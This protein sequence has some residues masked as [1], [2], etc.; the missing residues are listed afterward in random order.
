M[1]IKYFLRNGSFK[2]ERNGHFEKEENII[3]KEKVILDLFLL[4]DESIRTIPNSYLN[5]IIA[6]FPSSS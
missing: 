1:E 2:L 5:A 6:L 3:H 4:D